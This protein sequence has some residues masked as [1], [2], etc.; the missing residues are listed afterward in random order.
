M[1]LPLYTLNLSLPRVLIPKS[2]SLIMLGGLLYF[3][4]WLNLLILNIIIPGIY[5]VY[6]A[7]FIVILVLLQAI[8]N[9]L[10]Y[11]NYKY[12]FFKDKIIYEGKTE[13]I[14]NYRDVQNLAF[15]KDFFD[16]IFNTGTIIMSPVHKIQYVA[17]TNQMY[18]YVQ[19][20][21][22]YYSTNIRPMQQRYPSQ[23]QYYR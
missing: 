11:S 2:I 7:V 17:N 1:E 23:N 10:K 5:H 8:L 12:L 13:L 18:F 21:L 20:L 22:Q 6:I 3:G 19:K 4:V 15:S 9:Y 16:N 14:I